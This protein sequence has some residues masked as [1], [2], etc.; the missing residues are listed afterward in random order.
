[1][2]VSPSALI[3]CLGLGLQASGQVPHDPFAAPAS[4]PSSAGP[5]QP[6]AASRPQ[7][8]VTRQSDVEIPFS[9]RP[10][11]SPQ[12][13]PASVRVFVS[14]DRGKSWHFYD[15][16]RPDEGRFRFRPKQDGEFWFATQT[17]DR[18]GR[19][20]SPDPRKP[21]LRLIVDTQR[22]NLLVQAQVQPS[23][24]VAVAWSAADPT[25]APTS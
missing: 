9:V 12:A 18:S 3:V 19:P 25:L 24:E 1:M 4:S 2:R 15:E 14:W 17:I 13:E 5:S 6:A 8:Y 7:P 23:G 20:D 22:P 10:G 16:R 11:N 21:Q